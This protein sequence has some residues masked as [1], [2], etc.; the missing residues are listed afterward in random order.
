MLPKLKVVNKRTGRP[1]KDAKIGTIHRCIAA[2]DVS[3]RP[4]TIAAAVAA[5][6]VAAGADAVDAA[7]FP[8]LAEATVSSYCN[9]DADCGRDAD[10]DC[11]LDADADCGRDADADCGRDGDADRCS[12]KVAAAASVVGAH[13]RG[14]SG[15][16]AASL[17]E[18]A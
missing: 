16:A 9:A 18:D 7:S 12:A 14:G 13:A 3:H 1:P 4:H 11:G 15:N 2:V 5:F 17:S 8:D 10:A 6:P